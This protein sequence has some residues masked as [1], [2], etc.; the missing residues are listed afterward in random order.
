MAIPIKEVLDRVATVGDKQLMVF[1]VEH[2]PVI[3]HGGDQREPTEEI[4]CS[5]LKNGFNL[6]SL[7]IPYYLHLYDALKKEGRTLV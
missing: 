3:K 1:L 5:C 4:S 6:A 7:S 2:A